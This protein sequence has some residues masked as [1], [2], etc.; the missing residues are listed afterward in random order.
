MLTLKAIASALG[1]DVNGN[2]VL[3]PGPGHSPRDRSLAIRISPD[4]PDGFLTYSHAGDDFR[5][6]RD[7]VRARLGINGARAARAPERPRPAPTPTDKAAQHRKAAWMWAHSKPIAGSPAETYLR[8]TRRISCAIPPT[9]KYLPPRK[10]GQHPAMVAPFA[11]FDEGEPG[12]FGAPREIVSSVHLTLLTPDGRK[13]DVKPNKIVVGSPRGRPIIL[14]MW[15]DSLALVIVEGIEDGLSIYEKTGL[16]VWCAG[17]ASFMPALA[18]SVP[19]WIETVTVVAD[20]DDAGQEGASKLAAAL[21]RRGIR[22]VR[23]A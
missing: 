9:L 4:A 2:Q 8:E 3:C 21:Q 22:E 12:T 14:S 19:L 5:V 20:D 13:A 17:S 11:L 6:C 16:P 23:I 10:P 1:G 18:P 15:N 7:H